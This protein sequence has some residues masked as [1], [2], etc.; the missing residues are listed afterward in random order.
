M[1]I[2]ELLKLSFSGSMFAMA[3]ESPGCTGS[4][5]RDNQNDNRQNEQGLDRV[6][7]SGTPHAGEKREQDDDGGAEDDAGRRI[8]DVQ[9]LGH[10]ADG[11][12]LRCA[13]GQADQNDCPG[14]DL[15]C[16]GLKRLEM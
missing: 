8:A 1:L 5:E 15:L 3:V 14:G 10:C 12:E 9:S 11:L 6:G 4:S 2:E 13:G 7:D 16:P